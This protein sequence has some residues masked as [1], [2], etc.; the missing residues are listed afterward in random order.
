MTDDI[1]FPNLEDLPMTDDGGPAFPQA[2]EL[3]SLSFT[4]MS[5]RDWFA[6]MALGGC[7]VTVRDNLDI[8]YFERENDIAKRCYQIADAMLAIRNKEPR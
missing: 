1:N 6:G 8:D 4:G 2:R 7:E 3:G 5:L